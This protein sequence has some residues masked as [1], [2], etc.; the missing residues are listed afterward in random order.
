MVPT[1]FWLFLLGKGQPH[2]KNMPLH[3]CLQN[4]KKCTYTLLKEN[5]YRTFHIQ[6]LLVILCMDKQ[7]VNALL[8]ENG[9]NP[10]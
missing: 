5:V 3:K 4:S 6:I 1:A 8:L 2:W 9:Y 7:L 10:F